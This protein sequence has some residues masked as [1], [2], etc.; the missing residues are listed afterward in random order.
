M[1]P[2]EQPLRTIAEI[3]IGLAIWAA[4]VWPVAVVAALANR[5]PDRPSCCRFGHWH[6]YLPPHSPEVWWHHLIRLPLYCACILFVA[7][8]N[9]LLLPPMLVAELWGKLRARRTI[10]Y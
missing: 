6:D 1:I 7:L 2:S 5:R 9:F 8:V 10:K 4:I 3:L